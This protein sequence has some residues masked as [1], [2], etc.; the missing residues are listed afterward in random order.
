MFIAQQYLNFCQRYGLMVIFILKKL[1]SYKG[2]CS[3]YPS[4]TDP[5]DFF[6]YVCHSLCLFPYL[7]VSLSLC[8]SLWLPVIVSDC[9]LLCMSAVLS[10]SLY[11]LLSLH[12]CIF[13]F[14]SQFTVSF[15]LCVCIC[16]C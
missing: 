11:I 5:P 16:V 3:Q 2:H 9:L 10:L 8:L 12:F 15:Y 7:Y 6:L 13:I 14:V 4:Y 1:Q